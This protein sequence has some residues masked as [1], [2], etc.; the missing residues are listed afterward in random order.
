MYKNKLIHMP[1]LP[2]V[3]LAVV[4]KCVP[5]GNLI[6]AFMINQ[7]PSVIKNQITISATLESTNPVLLV[8]TGSANIP[9][10]MVVP[11]IR[12]IAPMQA[13]METLG[14]DKPLPEYVN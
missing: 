12:K 5:T 9:P 8:T 11:T 13:N 14:A 7:A 4:I 2:V 1:K 10:P 6:L 3:L